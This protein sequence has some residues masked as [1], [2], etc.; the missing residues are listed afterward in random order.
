VCLFFTLTEVEQDFSAAAARQLF[1]MIKIY[2]CVW[3][4]GA[5]RQ[6]PMHRKE[7]KKR[8]FAAL[9]GDRCA[10]TIRAAEARPLLKTIV[11]PYMEIRLGGKN[12]LLQLLAL[13]I[14]KVHLSEQH[15]NGRARFITS[16]YINNVLNKLLGDAGERRAIL[17]FSP[18]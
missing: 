3:L 13:P 14:C 4:R 1:E 11:G 17:L 9:K 10:T 6:Q 2:V 5:V 8:P 15:L 16:F 7:R 18:S 12:L